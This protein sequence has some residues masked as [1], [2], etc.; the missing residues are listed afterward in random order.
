MNGNL[1]SQTVATV[2]RW[3]G[4]RHWLALLFW[5]LNWLVVG[6]LSAQQPNPPMLSPE[7]ALAAIEVSEGFEVELVAAEPLVQDPVNFDW[8]PDGRLWVVEMA[9]YPL[10]L[11]GTGQPGGRVK[12]LEDTDGDGVYDRSTLFADGLNTPTGIMVWRRGVLVSGAPDITYLE[13]ANGDGKADKREVLFTG[14]AEGNQQHRVNGFSYGLDN[15]V[16]LA[17]GDSGGTVKSIKTGKTL[18][19]NG[20]DL[21]IRPDTG[22][23]ETQS[24]QTQFGRHRDDWGNW[25]GCNNPNPIFHFVMDERYLRRN[26]HAKYPSSKR[27]IRQGPVDV[28]PIGPFISHC[29]TKYQSDQASWPGHFAWVGGWIWE[30]SV[31]RKERQYVPKSRRH[32]QRPWLTRVGSRS[33]LPWQE[34]QAQQRRGGSVSRFLDRCCGRS[35]AS[36]CCLGSDSPSA[37]IRV[38]RNQSSTTWD[39]DPGDQSVAGR[40]Q[41]YDCVQLGLLDGPKRETRACHRR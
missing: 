25:F 5:M 23:M 33:L 29:D 38:F 12:V 3:F 31:A 16:Y 41:K 27:D 6:E 19:I 36:I 20:R 1:A 40:R 14:F 24:G 32:S 11:D 10:G 30:R 2:F 22:E 34:T 4:S 7:D 26:P 37:Y 9:D 39:R 15:W 8:G 18:P 13:D 28:F 21:R 17:N 35:P